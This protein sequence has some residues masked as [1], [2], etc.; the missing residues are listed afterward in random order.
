MDCGKPEKAAHR[1]EGERMGITID[2]IEMT[3]FCNQKQFSAD[4]SNRTLIKGKNREGKSTIRNAI[5]YLLTDKDANNNSVGDSIRP[6]DTNG[7]RQDHID[8]GVS[9]TVSVGSEHYKLTKIQR[10]KW[11]KKRGQEEQEFS[12]NENIYFI[13]DI[14]KS[15]K[16]FTAFISENICN[17]DDLPFCI[18]ANAFLS[19]DSKKR[20]AKV[21]SLAKSVSDAELAADS[22]KFSPLASDLKVGTVEEIMKRQKQTIAALKKQQTE[23]PARI[24]EVSKQKVDYDFA[25]LEL[26]KNGLCEKL[27]EIDKADSEINQK[28]NQIV[29]CEAQLADIEQKINSAAIAKRSNIQVDI[30]DLKPNL[31]IIDN[32]IER[33]TGEQA[34]LEKMV[35]NNKKALEDAEKQIELASAKIFDDS[36]LICPNCGQ[37]YPAEQQEELRRKFEKNVA[38][39][40]DRLSDYIDSLKNGIKTVEEKLKNVKSRLDESYEAKRATEK[41]VSMKEKELEMVKDAN[42]YS[43]GE[44]TA[45]LDEIERLQ[46]EVDN[47]KPVGVK[48]EI[49]QEI[50]AVEHKLAQAEANNRV[51]ERITELEQ[52]KKSVGAKL[53]EAEKL[54]YLIEEFN[55]E[56]I[57]RLE[58]AVNQ[59]FEIIKWRF[60]QEQI[61]GGYTE[62][63]RAIVDGTDYDTLLNKSDRLLCQVDICKGFQKATGINLPLLMDDCETVD[64][65]RLPDT[66]HQQIFFMR[67]DCKL[68]V[69]EV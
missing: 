54:L 25:E 28:K 55:R 24:D 38:E 53:L 67:D 43:D 63:C 2:H 57:A 6:H 41:A 13:N 64:K 48:A 26:Q 29:K 50:S 68:T 23:I 69:E 9:A 62:V 60:F 27:S 39:E 46:D 33:F 32:D 3:N 16:E 49:E 42:V 31:K 14:P 45:K 17:M 44:Y 56:K 18:N 36:S 65:D 66:D 10:Q 58:D 30:A 21:L 59:Y 19:L 8:I 52:E 37:E 1:K 22:E 11:V 34:E 4:F 5:L 20:R 12:G 15:A 61:N 35:A 51:D 40:A 47:Y 7:V